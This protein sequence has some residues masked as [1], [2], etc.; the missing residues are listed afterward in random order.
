VVIAA[1][2]LLGE[3]YDSALLWWSAG[4]QVSAFVE[5]C[6]ENRHFRGFSKLG[7]SQIV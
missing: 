5:N 1:F 6:T 2:C 4:M 7:G 3:K